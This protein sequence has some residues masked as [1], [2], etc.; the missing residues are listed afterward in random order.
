VAVAGRQFDEAFAC[1]DAALHIAP[2]D[3]E[4][5]RLRQE[6]EQSMS[7]GKAL[8]ESLQR[9][10]AALFAGDLDEAE[11]AIRG[12]L[13][14]DENNTDARALRRVLEKEL[15]ER[16]NRAKVREYINEARQQISNQDF[17]SAL[18]LLE[19]ARTLDP[20]D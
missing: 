17:T 8:R 10:E 4:L 13:E 15:A 20:S 19:Q 16:S 1:V 5:V 12:A 6:I 3:R 7:K 9:G 14:V 11:N 18:N 2:E